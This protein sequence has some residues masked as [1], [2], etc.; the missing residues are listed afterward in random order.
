MQ[1][2]AERGRLLGLDASEILIKRGLIG[3]EAYGRALALGLGLPFQA[4]TKALPIATPF[5]STSDDEL[6]AAAL[7]RADGR[8][9]EAEACAR[10]NSANSGSPSNPGNPGKREPMPDGVGKARDFDQFSH[11][12]A[13]PPHANGGS[14][15]PQPD[16]APLRRPDLVAPH[17]HAA[18]AGKELRNFAELLARNPQVSNRFS[19]TTKRANREGL[20][21]LAQSN[22]SDHARFGL[23]RRSRWLSARTTVTPWQAVIVLIVLQFIGWGMVFAGGRTALVVHLA[24]TCFYLA[25]VVVR[26]WASLVYRPPEPPNPPR[27]ADKDLP[28]YT[29]LVPLYREEQMVDGLV[30]SLCQIDWPVERLEIKLICEAD[31]ASTIKAAAAALLAKGRAHFEVVRVPPSL[32]RTKPKA[33]NFALAV[34][35]GQLVTVY[36]AEDRPHPGQLREAHHTFVVSDPACAVLQ[37]PLVITNGN[38]SWLA[39]MFEIEYSAL[40]DGLLPALSRSRLL[41]PLGGTSNHFKRAALDTVGGW[42][43]HNVTED[44]DLGVRMARAGLG[45]RAIALPTYEEAPEKFRV[46]LGQR[47]RWFKGWM[48]TWLVHTRHPLRFGRQ[49]G[50]F[51]VLVFHLLITGMLASALIHPFFWISAALYAGQWAAQGGL[52]AV[53]STLLFVDVGTLLMGYGALCVL[54]AQT[55]PQRGLQGH[56]PTLLALPVYW[57]LLSFAAWRALFDLIRRPHHWEKT[58][59]GG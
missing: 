33:L 1:E 30:T 14:A 16:A 58:A 4:E 55:L 9:H 19:I 47:T 43:P 22:L 12:V 42:D 6:A 11:M 21:R 28:L 13:V 7:A 56:R 26:L 15:D 45:F 20:M 51:Q 36:D 49:V 31:D 46:W 37:A 29:V 41:A 57:L 18:P 54:A 27:Y 17:F 59:H 3:E 40:F 38:K 44:A 35:C 10:S 39:R 34:S 52:P 24:V 48:Q 5:T 32:P 25:C 53:P 50:W 23:W 8:D 2:A